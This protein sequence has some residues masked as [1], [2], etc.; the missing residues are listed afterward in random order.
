MTEIV[1]GTVLNINGSLGTV[2]EIKGS[3]G[4]VKWH[5]GSTTVWG[6]NGVTENQIV[7]ESQ[8]TIFQP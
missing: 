3:L 2:I 6:L 4:L 7:K 1:V 8:L 5:N